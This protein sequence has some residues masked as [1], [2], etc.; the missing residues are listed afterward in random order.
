MLALLARDGLL[1]FELE[2]AILLPI[3]LDP[4]ELT[5]L[6]FSFIYMD[7]VRLTHGTLVSV[8]S[9]AA[10]LQS[11]QTILDKVDTPLARFWWMVTKGAENFTVPASEWMGS[12]RILVAGAHRPEPAFDS[13]KLVKKPEWSKDG[14][15][16]EIADLL[17]YP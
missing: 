12:D 15:L 5:F 3:A 13:A 11:A 9:A 17:C 1:R 4:V 2:S 14:A 16:D 7:I 6:I 8:K 10:A